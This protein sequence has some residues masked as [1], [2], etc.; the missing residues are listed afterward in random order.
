MT[1]E[2]GEHMERASGVLMAVSSLPNAYG[3]GTFGQEAYRFVD[4]LARTK[5][6]YWQV[7]PLTTTSYGDS[8]YQSFSAAAGNPYFI[9]LDA[10]KKLGYLTEHDFDDLNFGSDPARVDYGTLFVLHKMS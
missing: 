2:R 8:P 3:I 4:F 9:D 5:Q 10:L 6:R 1:R 7:L